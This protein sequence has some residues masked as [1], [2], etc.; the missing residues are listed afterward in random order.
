MKLK[1]SIRSLAAPVMIGAL[2]SQPAQAHFFAEAHDCKAPEK[3]L[4]F[5]TDLDRDEFQQQ[6]DAYRGCLQS[7]VDKQNKAMQNHQQA[8]QRAADTWASFQE[9]VLE[10]EPAGD[11]TEAAV[12]AE[13][14]A[15]Q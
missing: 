1:H 13:Q 15:S 10:I 5:I 9:Q 3:P 14:S 8:A 4:E 7:F 12:P 6:V 11:G 2:L